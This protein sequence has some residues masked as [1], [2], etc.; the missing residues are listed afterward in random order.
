MVHVL[1]FEILTYLLKEVTSFPLD[2]R[3]QEPIMFLNFTHSPPSIKFTEAFISTAY[4]LDRL[5]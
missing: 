4:K 2:P 1:R 3:T 5:D